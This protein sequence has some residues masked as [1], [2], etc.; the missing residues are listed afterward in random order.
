VCHIIWAVLLRPGTVCC[1]SSGCIQ[2]QL[3]AALGLSNKSA[4]VAFVADDSLDCEILLRCSKLTTSIWCCGINASFLKPSDLHA[5]TTHSPRRTGFMV[6]WVFDQAAV[7]MLSFAAA[8][9][10][11]SSL[12]SVYGQARLQLACVC[13]WHNNDQHFKL[14][15]DVELWCSHYS[16]QLAATAFRV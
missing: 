12:I 3:V 9:Q 16:W 7:F 4:F 13:I 2:L 14:L 1:G 11:R 15:L 10:A 8:W 6:C 5:P